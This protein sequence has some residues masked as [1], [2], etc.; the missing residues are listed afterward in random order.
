[1]SDRSPAFRLEGVTSIE[2]EHA[3]GIDE[4]GNE[5]EE[6]QALQEFLALMSD[7]DSGMRSGC[8]AQHC[9]VRFAFI[10]QR[11]LVNNIAVKPFVDLSEFHVLGVY[12]TMRAW[13]L[14]GRNRVRTGRHRL[15]HRPGV[16]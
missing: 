2:S 8:R 5:Q 4:A 7:Y 6:A 16:E 3:F 1:M 15:G 9:W 13:W 12:D 10:F 11:C 14:G